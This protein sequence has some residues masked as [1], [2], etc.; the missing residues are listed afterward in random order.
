MLKLEDVKLAVAGLGY[1]GLPLAVEFGKQ[2]AVVGFDINQRRVQKLR[3]G[4]DGTLEV[5][6]ELLSQARGLEFTTDPQK[7]GGLQ[8]LY[9]LPTPIDAHKRPD[10]IPLVELFS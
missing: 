9:R 10:L 6:N 7:T 1:V 8:C 5:E 2:R 3:A 4:H